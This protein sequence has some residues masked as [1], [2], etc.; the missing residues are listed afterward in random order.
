MKKLLY[1]FILPILGLCLI[2]ASCEDWT[3]ME[4]IHSENMT[5]SVFTEEYYASQP[6]G[7]AD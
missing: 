1:M 2:F 4:P 6:G 3:E 5:G 7:Y